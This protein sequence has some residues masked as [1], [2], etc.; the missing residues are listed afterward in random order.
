MG[1]CNMNCCRCI[2]KKE[3]QINQMP[4]LSHKLSKCHTNKINQIRP[5]DISQILILQN[6]NKDYANDEKT[7]LYTLDNEKNTGRKKYN[8]NT[9]SDLNGDISLKYSKKKIKERFYSPNNRYDNIFETYK[10]KTKEIEK[11]KTLDMKNN[12]NKENNE[13]KKNKG[14]KENN[15]FFNKEED[16]EIN[17]SKSPNIIPRYLHTNFKTATNSA[18]SR[19]FDEIDNE[20]KKFVMTENN[21]NKTNNNN[22]HPIKY[23]Y[24]KDKYITYFTDENL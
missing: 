17:D 16:A 11:E 22:I 9:I 23:N 7:S 4:S 1:N 8:N 14:N 5:I 13:D 19:Y 3:T 21:K 12:N 20:K 10:S 6:N 18:Y 2:D 15:D 24:L